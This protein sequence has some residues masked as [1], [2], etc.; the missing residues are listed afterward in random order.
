MRS[1]PVGRRSS[2][3]FAS[4]TAGAALPPLFSPCAV[5]WPPW[6]S[7]VSTAFLPT[8]DAFASLP[9]TLCSN[10]P[11]TVAALL[12]VRSVT[13]LP[14]LLLIP[15]LLTVRP[16]CSSLRFS[17]CHPPG[18]RP[19]S[20]LPP[21]FSLFFS[22]A[23]APSPSL[24][25][26]SPLH[27]LCASQTKVRGRLPCVTSDRALVY[28]F[29]FLYR[30]FTIP[31]TRARCR[32][33]EGD[34]ASRRGQRAAGVRI[35]ADT[36]KQEEKG[37]AE[38]HRARSGRFGCPARSWRPFLAFSVPQPLFPFLR[39]PGVEA[40]RTCTH[41]RRRSRS[42]RSSAR[43]QMLC[44]LPAVRGRHDARG[45]LALP[46]GVVVYQVRLEKGH[47]GRVCER[48][49]SKA[50]KKE[51][52]WRSG[53]F[54]LFQEPRQETRVQ[55]SGLE[56]TFARRMRRKRKLTAVRASEYSASLVL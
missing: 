33:S 17:A 39:R 55:F 41:L 56:L 52:W 32:A 18:N 5:L 11:P 36:E 45:R 1:T 51:C 42:R 7:I 44:A 3:A 35:W 37:W 27:C 28:P 2:E 31:R 43:A 49:G 22:F 6:I 10:G 19:P 29:S 53:A 40:A 15:H 14:I 46:P 16:V 21:V 4:P 24:L 54:A 9:R 12:P 13:P 26:F 48:G 30:H 38:R 23:F 50:T 20:G 47:A 34:R 25:H 8:Q